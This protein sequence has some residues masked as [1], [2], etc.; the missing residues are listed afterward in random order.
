MWP[1]ILY[2]RPCAIHHAL[3]AFYL[4]HDFALNFKRR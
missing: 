1:V 4:G 2:D 3:I